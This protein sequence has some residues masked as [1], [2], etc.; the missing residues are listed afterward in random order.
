MEAASVASS[1]SQEVFYE[2][3]PTRGEVGDV[4]EQEAANYTA[5]RFGT[6]ASPYLVKYIYDDDGEYL[7]TI[8]DQKGWC[9]YDW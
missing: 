4:D 7:D 6:T 9:L 5:I 3:A 8:W 1:P 2:T